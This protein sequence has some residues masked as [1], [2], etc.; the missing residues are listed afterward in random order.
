MSETKNNTLPL[1]E[2]EKETKK[3][4]SEIKKNLRHV[5]K[6][7]YSQ[8]FSDDVD[9]SEDFDLSEEIHHETSLPRKR[10]RTT[11]EKKPKSEV[12]SSVKKS[13]NPEIQNDNASIN[14][15]EKS[16]NET[17]ININEILSEENLKNNNNNLPNSDLILIIFEI[18][19]NSNQF[20]V[21]K[22]NSS[23]AF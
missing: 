1:N 5:K 13:E 7:N 18:C 16:K 14:N 23:R 12:K 11:T 6:I 2:E 3:S 19:L 20:G 22:D 8:Y 4:E 21:D 10:R 15:D 17:I 9:N